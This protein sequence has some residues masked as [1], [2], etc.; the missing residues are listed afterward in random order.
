MSLLVLLLCNSP[1]L[2]VSSGTGFF[3]TDD[4]YLVTNHHVV[5]GAAMLGIRAADGKLYRATLA[6]TDQANDL[7]LLKVDGGPFKAISIKPSGGAKKGE[8]VFTIGFPQ[9][10]LQGLEAKL[11]DGLISS[12]S[13]LRGEPNTFQVSVPVQPGN[14]GGPLFTKDGLAIGIIVSKLSPLATI[15]GGS[16]PENVN[17]AIKSNYLLEFV[18]TESQV[19]RKLKPV[20]PVKGSLETIVEEVEPAVVLVIAVSPADLGKH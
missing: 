19:H 18:R 14:S 13:G 15:G 6:R 1:V 10:H 9:V 16:I 8:S 20:V 3:V 7:A 2:A 5:D 12:L 17:Y 11:T 4:G